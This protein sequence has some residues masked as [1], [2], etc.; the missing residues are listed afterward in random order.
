MTADMTCCFAIKP[1]LPVSQ[2]YYRKLNYWM[3]ADVTK[4]SLLTILLN[5]EVILGNLRYY[6][7]TNKGFSEKEIEDEFKNNVDAIMQKFGG[8]EQT[9]RFA[10]KYLRS[11]FKE[12]GQEKVLQYIN[13]KYQ[14]LVEECDDND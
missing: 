14:K 8:N 12:I 2:D 6:M 11:S 13:E 9:E 4:P 3:E 10:L 5:T 1:D 7:S